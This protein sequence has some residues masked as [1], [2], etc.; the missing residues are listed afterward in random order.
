VERYFERIWAAL[1]RPFLCAFFE[2]KNTQSCACWGA[3]AKK[4][5]KGFLSAL[6]W[7]GVN[8]KRFFVNYL[9]NFF[10]MAG[11]GGVDKAWPV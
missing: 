10:P 5:V 2:F 4:F 6:P 8:V 7:P 3:R 9:Q 11:P 1:G